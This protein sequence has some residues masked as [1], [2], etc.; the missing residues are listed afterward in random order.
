M[1][2]NAFL[3]TNI[4][5]YAYSDTEVEKQ[6]VARR[7]AENLTFISTQVLQE[8]SNTLNRK[9]KKTWPEITIAIQDV[10]KNK[11]VHVNV[12]STILQAIKIAGLYKFSFY[13]SL[14]ISAAP[15]CN[16]S[17]LY[18]EDMSHGQII[19]KRLTIINPFVPS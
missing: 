7:V 14:I 13:D 4:L 12:E 15:E 2:V 1:S 17:K 6:I 11:K 3:D 10:S 8:F 16:C 9:F 5:V 19:E 18:S